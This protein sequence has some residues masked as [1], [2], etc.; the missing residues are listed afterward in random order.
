[1]RIES[2]EYEDLASGWKLERVD[3]DPRLNLLVG[4]SGAGKTR[5][6]RALERMSFSLLVRSAFDAHAQWRLVSVH[7]GTRVR[8]SGRTRPTSARDLSAARS[9][10][11]YLFESERLEVDGEV[12]F[13]RRDGRVIYRGEETPSL[14]ATESLLEVLDDEELRAA[15]ENLT[16]ITESAV[17]SGT[18]FGPGYWQT[19]EDDLESHQTE[20]IHPSLIGGQTLLKAFLLERLHPEHF[21]SIVHLYRDIFPAVESV[22][23]V[24]EQTAPGGDRWLHFEIRERGIRVP[25]SEREMSSGMRRALYH[26]FDIA[27]AAPG[28]VIIIDEFE[29]S[30]G[31]NCLPEITDFILEHTDRVQFILTS[32]HPYIINQIPMEHWK[33]VQRRGGTVSVHDADEFADLAESS[34]LD[35]FTRLINSPAYLEGVSA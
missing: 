35:Q 15:R 21:A 19:I 33:L 7:D 27:L 10:E 17:S 29:N 18:R 32:H 28:S 3:F 25:I 16:S 26:L 6:V 20:D 24:V 2:F 23:V 14:H 31:V 11:G 34:R 9:G 1:M 13:E 12:V 30:F 22:T 4:A 8:W 5:M